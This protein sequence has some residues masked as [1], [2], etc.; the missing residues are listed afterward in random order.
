MAT[1]F[2]SFIFIF[3][4]WPFGWKQSRADGKKES[5]STL[6][7]PLE[8]IFIFSHSLHILRLHYP[9]EI[10]LRDSRNKSEA[11]SKKW[12]FNDKKFSSEKTFLISLMRWW[13]YLPTGVHPT[14]ILMALSSEHE[15]LSTLTAAIVY[16]RSPAWNVNFH[17]FWRFPLWKKQIFLKLN[18]IS[19]KN[20]GDLKIKLEIGS[21]Q[22]YYRSCYCRIWVHYVCGFQ[23]TDKFHRH[24]LD[25]LVNFTW[26]VA[27]N[28]KHQNISFRMKN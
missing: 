2:S 15:T 11:T 27:D 26:V 14:R 18:Q 3:P 16:S 1:T 20:T 8:R 9:S 4:V 13:L 28:N 21:K 7:F 5:H 23:Q 17:R 10:T 24:D 22:K 25:L 19:G 12:K 6:L